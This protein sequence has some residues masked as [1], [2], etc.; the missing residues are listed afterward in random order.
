MYDI[1]LHYN[2]NEIER[3]SWFK[4]THLGPQNSSAKKSI[5]DWTK[6]TKACVEWPGPEDWVV[7]P[8]LL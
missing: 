8:G 1:N 7:D 2:G 5:D 6:D 3:C 4:C